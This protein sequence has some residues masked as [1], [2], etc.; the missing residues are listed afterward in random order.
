MSPLWIFA[1]AV[2]AYALGACDGNRTSRNGG[3][4]YRNGPPPTDRP[5]PRPSPPPPPPPRKGTT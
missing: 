1:L 5:K 3:T 2:I 4:F